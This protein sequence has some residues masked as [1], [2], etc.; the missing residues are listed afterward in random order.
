MKY[1]TLLLDEYALSCAC[2]HGWGFGGIGLLSNA[3]T[4]IVRGVY[5]DAFRPGE[6][7]E[8]GHRP[9]WY[10]DIAVTVVLCWLWHK[11]EEPSFTVRHLLWWLW[12]SLF[13][14]CWLTTARVL[15]DR[16]PSIVSYPVRPLFGGITSKTE[17]FKSLWSTGYSIH[18]PPTTLLVKARSSTSSSVAALDSKATSHPAGFY[19]ITWKLGLF[20]ADHAQQ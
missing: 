20:H 9:S 1:F 4:I 2:L 5:V 7:F 6:F 19:I 17:N 18:R 16:S 10:A 3:C 12:V 13:R 14:W 15:G 8:G 11:S